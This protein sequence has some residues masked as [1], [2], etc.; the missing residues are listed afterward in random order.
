MAGYVAVRG[1]VEATTR[2]ASSR[3]ERASERAPV[4]QRRVG[5]RAFARQLMAPSSVGSPVDAG[6]RRRVE[7]A[8]G[9]SLAGVRVHTDAVAERSAASLGA[10]A[11]T[12]GRDLHFGRG[13]YRPGSREGERLIAHELVHAIQQGGSTAAP[14]AKLEVSEPG[15]AGEREADAIADAIVEGGEVDM[16][17]RVRGG[18][19]VQRKILI[20]APGNWRRMTIAPLGPAPLVAVP[21][22]PD[23]LRIDPPLANAGLGPRN[24][25]A[26]VGDGRSRYFNDAQEVADFA[27]QRTEKIGYVDREKTW[28]RLPDECLVLGELHAATT[29]QDLVDATGNTHFQYEGK[30]RTTT[31]PRAADAAVDRIKHQLEPELPKMVVGLHGMRDLFNS[32]PTR[33]SQYSYLESAQRQVA[34]PHTKTQWKQDN[35]R[36]AATDRE[37]VVPTP[38]RALADF[39]AG[40][41][42]QWSDQWERDNAG[43]RAGARRR[44]P[45]LREGTFQAPVPRRPYDRDATEAFYVLEALRYLQNR[46]YFSGDLR[47]F[48]KDHRSIINTTVTELAANVKLLN[49]TLFRKVVTGRFDLDRAITL[50]EAH[51]LAEF[52]ASGVQDVDTLRGYGRSYERGQPAPPGGNDHGLRMEQLRDSYMLE[53]IRRAAD[54]DVQLIGVGDLHRQNLARI[55]TARYPDWSVCDSAAFYAAQYRKHPDSA[56]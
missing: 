53:S 8:T 9:A 27:A 51:A 44:A 28:V 38:E 19:S 20:G 26:M 11:Y 39:E 7:A 46:P 1:P 24:V 4:A 33:W 49:T 50:F 6:L 21:P 40:D 30:A 18:A 17:V 36:D 45:N 48:Y 5:N 52:R 16:P 2:D 14:Q 22:A 35:K 47:D 54:N 31:I 3:A 56:L 23:P 41:L 25:R 42:Q 29:L 34:A 12:L 15:D 55:V 13:E 37:R 43:N 10:R 32:L